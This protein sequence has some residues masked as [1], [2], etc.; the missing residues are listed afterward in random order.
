LENIRLDNKQQEN[1]RAGVLLFTMTGL[2]IACLDNAA[3]CQNLVQLL[4]KLRAVEIDRVSVRAPLAQF[5]NFE[6]DR[7]NS[8]TGITSQTNIDG[9]SQ[10]ILY[11]F[12]VV[13]VLLSLLAAWS[14]YN[15]K[16]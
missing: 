16:R 8:S 15:R 5:S 12:G 1:G 13:F 2:H 7:S 9:W 14:K 3:R 6:T 10:P 4:P 11:I